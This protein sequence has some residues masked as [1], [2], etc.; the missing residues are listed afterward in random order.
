MRL[1][2][3]HQWGA[4]VGTGVGA[5]LK[6]APTETRHGLPE[7]VRAWKTFSARRI[8]QIRITPGMKLW[9]RNYW[10]HIIRNDDELNR[11]RQYVMDNPMRWETDRENPEAV[12]SA[13]KIR[14]D[15][16]GL[17]A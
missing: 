5:G 1:L 7:I 16:V 13:G 9:Q 14:K 17:G 11:I 4:D 6:P 2:S 10:E 8:N 12:K 15:F 3:W